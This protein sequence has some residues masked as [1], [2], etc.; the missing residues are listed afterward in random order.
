MLETTHTHHTQCD[1]SDVIPDTQQHA[2]HVHS[3][4]HC[5]FVTLGVISTRLKYVDGNHIRV[6]TPTTHQPDTV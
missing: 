1:A 4:S 3:D 6:P 5:V 2:I